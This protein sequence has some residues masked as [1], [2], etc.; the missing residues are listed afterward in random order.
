MDIDGSRRSAT[1]DSSPPPLTRHSSRRLG[2][3]RSSRAARAREDSP[4][5]RS[6]SLSRLR[7]GADAPELRRD[8]LAIP[9]GIAR[10]DAARL[11]RAALTAASAALRR[12]LPPPPRIIPIVACA[13]IGIM[14]SAPSG[15]ARYARSLLR[16]RPQE[17]RHPASSRRRDDA[18][19]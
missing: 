8:L 10:E 18:A 3:N 12:N 4:S 15:L 9:S 19:T 2:V 17:P 16:A 13:K 5:L 6:G 1:R 14:R 7:P 11:W